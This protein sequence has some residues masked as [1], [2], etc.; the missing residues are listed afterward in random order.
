MD[1]RVIR[2]KQILR[3]KKNW[4]SYKIKDI[5]EID[6]INRNDKNNLKIKNFQ[7]NMRRENRAYREIEIKRF[8]F[9]KFEHTA[10]I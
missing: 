7:E 9:V 10:A 6:H 5:N 3:L 4:F 8:V 2:L 1:K